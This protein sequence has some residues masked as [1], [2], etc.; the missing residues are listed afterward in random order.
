MTV[1]SDQCVSETGLHCET[2]GN[3][4][5][6]L[7]IHGL[8]SSTFTW[9]KLIDYP[10]LIQN[11]RL[12][13]VDL[14]G[15]GQSPKP[16]DK[17]YSIL[18]QADLIYQFILEQDLRDLILMGN[19]YGGGVSLLVAIRLCEQDRARFSKLILID[20]GGYDRKLPTHLKL[21]RT[22]I[23][24]WIALNILPARTS[25]RM[26]LK[27]AYYDK[28]EITR[29]Q[30]EAYAAPIAARGGRHALLETAKQAIPK[31]IDEITSRYKTICVPTLILW[32]REDKIIPLEIGE[33]LHRD[34]PDSKLQIVENAG[35]VPQEEVAGQ[36][37]PMIIEFISP[38][39]GPPR[40]KSASP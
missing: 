24:G 31:N 23:V 15:A 1:P 33:Q 8:G 21:L 6:I 5:P 34:I 19:S 26:I 29:D 28:N 36:V 22:P 40:D 27:Q 13:L 18:E 7:A 11:H 17:H 4:E 35:H 30:V 9:R 37:T 38:N 32:G 2:Y 12:I 16:H 3:G 25:A 20:S 14:R 39:S 10:G